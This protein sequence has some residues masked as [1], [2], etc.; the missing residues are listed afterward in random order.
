MKIAREQTIRDFLC[1][2]SLSV[3]LNL[4]GKCDSSFMEIRLAGGGISVDMHASVWLKGWI[5]CSDRLKVGFA[6]KSQ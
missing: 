5:S 1:P 6:N 2:T 3:S 4:H